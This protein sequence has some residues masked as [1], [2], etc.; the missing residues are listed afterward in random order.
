MKL[1]NIL[2]YL[3]TNGI[4]DFQIISDNKKQK[5]KTTIKKEDKSKTVIQ[6]E[7]NEQDVVKSLQ[8]IEKLLQKV[9]NK[10]SDVVYVEQNI[11]HTK[12]K[13]KEKEPEFIAKLN[14][15]GKIYGSS[16]TKKQ[17]DDVSDSVEAL[18]NLNK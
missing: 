13:E 12:K 4:S 5:I 6:D 17:V 10:E 2:L 3:Q 14:I 9:L 16:S 11:K 1:N 8:N 7:K 18:K 15:S